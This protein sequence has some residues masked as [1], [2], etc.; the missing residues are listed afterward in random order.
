MAVPALAETVRIATFNA[1]LTRGGAGLLL[2][3]LERGGSEQ[4][5]R[6]AAILQTVRPDIVLLNE[7][8][9]DPEGRALAAFVA[10]LGVSQRGAEPILYPHV[11]TAPPNTGVLTGF[12]LDGDGDAFG[13]RDAQGYG[14]F[15]GQYGMALLSRF[16][17]EQ[18]AVVSFV[19][20]LWKDLPG[21]IPP[22]HPK[23][24]PS[25]QRLSSKGHWDVPVV[26]PGGARVH[27][28][29]SHPTPPVFDGPEDFNGRRNHDEMR[30]WELYLDGFELPADGG[31]TRSAGDAPVILLGDLNADPEDG[32]GRREA[33]RRLLAHPR[34]QDPMPM[35]V[36]GAAAA[37]AQAGA[38]IQH[39]GD[40]ARDTADWNDARGPGNL[41]VDYVL[42]DARLEVVGAGVFWPAPGEAGHDLL[43]EG[44]GAASDHRLV[45]VD[46]RLPSR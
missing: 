46:V 42:P 19:A 6:V 3:D 22:D 17:F 15:P 9:H 43:G 26:L 8:D 44:R 12:D 45:W 33:I 25:V 10:H 36:G 21:A 35:S 1:S 32:D 31:G 5:D 37:E 41:R 23:Y 4:V 14:R 29:A 28:L 40:P 7:I 16:P 2:A 13:P 11:F 27:L 20:L 18:D 38:N 39:R 24:R 34:L 30:L